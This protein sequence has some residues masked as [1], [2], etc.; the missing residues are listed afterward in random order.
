MTSHLTDYGL[1]R[2]RK[3]EDKMTLEIIS[4]DEKYYDNIKTYLNSNKQL[5]SKPERMEE[6]IS[7][8]SNKTLHGI[9]LEKK[10]DLGET[11][12]VLTISSSHPFFIDIKKKLEE[13]TKE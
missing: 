1:E 12:G 6:S 5:L 9:I 13:I 8:Y 2:Y 11:L 3:V 4:F 7:Y 10:K